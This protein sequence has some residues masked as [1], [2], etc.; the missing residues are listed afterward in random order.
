MQVVTGFSELLLMDVEENDPKYEMLKEIES[1]IGRIGA[2]TRKIMGI[3][4][5]ESKPY[6]TT[7]IID[8]EQASHGENKN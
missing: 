7:K 6:L 3:T 8:I 5:Y 2:L 4:R 1:G